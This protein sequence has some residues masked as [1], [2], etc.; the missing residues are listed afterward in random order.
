[1]QFG[2]EGSENDGGEQ[3]PQLGQQQPTLHQIDDESAMLGLPSIALFVADQ[4]RLM[5]NNS[6]PML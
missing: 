6:M 1:M 5:M 4:V 3:P 2:D